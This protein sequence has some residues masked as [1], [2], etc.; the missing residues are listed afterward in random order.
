MTILPPTLTSLS[1][2][3]LSV[4]RRDAAIL[5]ALGSLADKPSQAENAPLSAL[6]Q[7][8]TNAGG[9]GMSA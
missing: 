8:Q 9:D 2:M 7:K 3:A 6:V 1:H 5:V 4:V